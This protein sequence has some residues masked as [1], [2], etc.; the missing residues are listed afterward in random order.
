MS[1]G[2]VYLNG[3]ILPA[4]EAKISIS[5]AGLLH[6]ASSFTTMLAHNGVVFRLDRHL[7]RLTETVDMLG[8][9]T[10]VG[11]AELAEATYR[12]LAANELS[13]ARIRITLTPG[14]VQADCPTAIITADPLGDYPGQWYTK[15]I[16]VVVS[17]WKQSPDDITCGCK[18]GCYLPRIVAR[19]AA[20][21]K[22]AEEAIW[23]TTDNY[24]AEACFNNIFLVLAG[25]VATPPTDT[26]VLPGVV[27]GAVIELCQKEGI[28]CDA[29]GKLTVKEML[30][31][32]EI[33]LTGSCTG[34]RPVVSVERHAVGDQTPGEVTKRI[35][36][37]YGRLLDAE[38]V[39]PVDG[40]QD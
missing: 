18:T 32:D 8:L 12:V 29:D 15:G 40:R 24:L 7:A 38:C 21:A 14:S 5:D 6:G 10:S 37:A 13:E 23:F 39:R 9:K 1:N 30:A 11:A 33:F 3:T 16:D 17:E 35:M 27:R 20:A 26:P 31:A 28:A 25:K 36:A 22:G 34:I 4:G 2:N 19:R